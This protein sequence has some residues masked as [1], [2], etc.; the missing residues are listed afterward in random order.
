MESFAKH[1]VAYRHSGRDR[2][3]LYIECLPLFMAARLRLLDSRRLVSQFAAL[4][5]RTTMGRDRVDHPPHSHDDCCNVVAGAAVLA[6]GSG[7]GRATAPVLVTQPLPDIHGF[8]LVDASGTDAAVQALCG[9]PPDG[10]AGGGLMPYERSG[11][12]YG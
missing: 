3:A 5:R 4:E 11:G 12:Y 1:G 6:A 9:I 10:M 2:S 7:L 8:G